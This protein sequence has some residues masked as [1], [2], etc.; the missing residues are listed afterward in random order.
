MDQETQNLVSKSADHNYCLYYNLKDE[1]VYVEAGASVGRFITKNL[2]NLDTGLSYN[3]DYLEL[4][5]KV[6]NKVIL[7]EPCPQYAS[8]LR[9]LI[10]EKIIEN[11][12]CIEKA[13]SLSKGKAKFINWKDNYDG[14]RLSCHEADFP[15][16]H[17]DINT[18]TIDNILTELN[19][20][21]VDLLA[22]DIEGKEVELIKSAQKYLFERRIKNIAICTYHKYPDNHNE[23]AEILYNYGFNKIRYEA[24][25]T[26]AKLRSDKE[27][28]NVRVLELD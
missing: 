2:R 7:I 8:I 28:Q 18:D 17:I 10:E 11:G 19:I 24:G 16:F 23:I 4:P 13:I 21:T 14:S 3:I 20:Q 5:T 1:D 25:I 9:Q 6:L 15:E 27:H 26:F 22:G 12:I